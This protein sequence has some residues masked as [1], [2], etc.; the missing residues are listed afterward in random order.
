MSER[1]A[2]MLVERSRDKNVLAVWDVEAKTWVLPHAT[3]MEGESL[4]AAAHRS[5]LACTNETSLSLGGGFGTNASPFFENA[6]DGVHGREEHC[7]AHYFYVAGSDRS[8]E[9]YAPPGPVFWFS[10]AELVSFSDY[11]T[12]YH[13]MFEA[14]DAQKTFAV[15][16]G[17]S[18]YLVHD[19]ANVL[20]KKHPG[21]DIV[22][23]DDL[24]LHPYDARDVV[25]K[26]QAK[27]DAILCTTNPWLV[28]LVAKEDVVVV[29]KRERF[30]LADHPD[31]KMYGKLSAGDFWLSLRFWPDSE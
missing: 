27:R 26:H 1:V 12:A 23:L 2:V 11:W 24:H 22:S 15:V 8:P 29:G 31:A 4:G 18:K 14:F 10:R 5:I 6:T 9:M 7:H 20:A 19:Q 25:L 13:L 17:R 28:N 21:T 3:A 16:V 30:R